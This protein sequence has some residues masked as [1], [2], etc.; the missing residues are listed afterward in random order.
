MNIKINSITIL[1][2]DHGPD[3]L[4][5]NTELP[6]GCFPYNGYVSLK[7]DVAK[8]AGEKYVKINFPGVEYRIIQI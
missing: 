5:L 1:I 4:Y 6:N 3:T 7:M 2:S 8:E